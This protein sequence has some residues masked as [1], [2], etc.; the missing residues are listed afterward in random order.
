MRATLTVDGADF[1]LDA[2][3]AFE[4]N[5][6]VPHSAFN[7][8]EEDRIHFVFEVFEGAVNSLF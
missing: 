7:G 2:G 1:H 6:L 4:V 8:G 5:D 3:C